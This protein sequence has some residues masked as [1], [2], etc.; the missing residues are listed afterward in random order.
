MDNGTSDIT[1]LENQINF[2][3][4]IIHWLLTF[5]LLYYITVTSMSSKRSE[6]F[7]LSTGGPW[8][9]TVDWLMA[10]SQLQ[11]SVHR[12]KIDLWIWCKYCSYA[13]VQCLTTFVRAS[14]VKFCAM[15]VDRLMIIYMLD[16]NVTAT[17]YSVILLK[18]SVE[19]KIRLTAKINLSWKKN[20][21]LP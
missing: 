17:T 14:R 19:V 3:F 13:L 18:I 4:I 9:D 10:D 7:I 12:F 11:H 5:V 16:F 6:Q 21:T 15:V 20:R 2:S 8:S 1:L